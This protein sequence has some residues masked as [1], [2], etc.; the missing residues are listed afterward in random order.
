VR[1]SIGQHSGGE[2]PGRLGFPD[3]GRFSR[4]GSEFA[5]VLRKALSIKCEQRKA[6]TALSPNRR[7]RSPSAASPLFDKVGLL[8]VFFVRLPLNDAF[9]DYEGHS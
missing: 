8:V 2:F 3:Q 7:F 6:I 1:R 9:D 5:E 4:D